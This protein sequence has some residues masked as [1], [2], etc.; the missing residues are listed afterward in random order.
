MEAQ[1]VEQQRQAADAKGRLESSKA[2]HER[3]L[4]DAVEAAQARLR[5]QLHEETERARARIDD[6]ER[7]LRDARTPPKEVI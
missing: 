4:A 1:L 6:L 2:V 5:Q 7:Q 3:A